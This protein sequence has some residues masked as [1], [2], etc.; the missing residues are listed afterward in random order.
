LY[1]VRKK[2]VP[3]KSDPGHVDAPS[4]DLEA[5]QQPSQSEA[6]A[7][8]KMPSQ[9]ETEEQQPKEGAE[10]FRPKSNVSIGQ[11][12]NNIL[13]MLKQTAEKK[14]EKGPRLDETLAEEF[15]RVR[16]NEGEEPEQGEA[17]K[18]QEVEKGKGSIRDR[19][20]ALFG[21]KVAKRPED[22]EMGEK[23]ETA[24]VEEGQKMEEEEATGEKKMEELEPEDKEEKKEEEEEVKKEGQR[25]GSETPV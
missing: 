15:E 9:S 6:S 22:V 7:A 13:A 2:Q 11:K 18:E 24:E 10:S 20:R 5:E 12:I 17:A 3:H 21:N 25:L 8:Q 16:L 23:K 14:G 4:T 1:F 19:I